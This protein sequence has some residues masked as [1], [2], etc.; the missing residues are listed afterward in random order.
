MFIRENFKERFGWTGDATQRSAGAGSCC[1]FLLEG[2]R[3][4]VTCWKLKPQ[5]ARRWSPRRVAVNARDELLPKGVGEEKGRSTLLFAFPLAA[6]S[7]TNLAR[8]ERT[9]EPGEYSQDQHLHSGTQT[10]LGRV[11]TGLRA[12][13]CTGSLGRI[14]PR[15][16][17]FFVLPI[18]CTIPLVLVPA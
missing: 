13:R 18:N 14:S 4:G 7:C 3:S 6:S 8:K 12:H 2:Q 5:Q 9:L 15:M 16:F 11:R 17:F 1:H 10:E